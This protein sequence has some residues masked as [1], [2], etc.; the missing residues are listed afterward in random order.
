MNV[1]QKNNEHLIKNMKSLDISLCIDDLKDILEL[2]SYGRQQIDS[3]EKKDISNWISD[4]F[5]D[6][7]VSKWYAHENPVSINSDIDESVYFIWAPTSVLKPY[8]LNGTIPQNGICIQQPSFRTHNAKRLKDDTPIRWWST[9]TGISCMSNY[10]DGKFLMK[11]TI[12]FLLNVLKIPLDNIAINISTKDKDLL[13]FLQAA[14]NPIRLVFDTKDPK[15]YTHRYWLGDIVW[16]NF[17]FVMKDEN[18]GM[19]NDIGNYIIIEDADKKYWI[20]SWFWSS[21]IMQHLYWL[22]HVLDTSI[23]SDI[24]LWNSVAHRKLQDSIVV[25]LLMCSLGIIP[26]RHDTK[27]RVLKR[28]IS[29]IKY[30]QELLN[31]WIDELEKILKLY[32]KEEYGSYKYS[33]YILSELNK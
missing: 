25:S 26:K 10:S 31:I 27:W 11:N 19:F 21:V 17:N 29:W 14:W 9:F 1:G 2:N 20:E 12:D 22:N 33:N 7:F 5:C 15:Y 24:V 16:R 30:N 8:L 23:I 28:Y 32:E 6:F 3:L 4:S 13:D 18:T